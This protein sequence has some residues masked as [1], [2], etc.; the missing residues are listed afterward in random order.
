MKTP[1][2]YEIL[3]K[4]IFRSIK[5]NLIINYFLNIIELYYLIIFVKKYLK[6][7]IYS[8]IIV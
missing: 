4:Y 3:L 8:Y 1:Q 6:I 7:N 5:W 2:K